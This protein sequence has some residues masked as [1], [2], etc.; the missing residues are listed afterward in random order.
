MKRVGRW[1][2]VRYKNNNYTLQP[3][4]IEDYFNELY[5]PYKCLFVTRCRVVIK[6]ILEMENVGR[7]EDVFI[8]PHSPYC[9]IEA[10]GKVSVPVTIPE[11]Q[12][13]KDIVYHQYGYRTVVGNPKRA[14]IIIEDA[15]DSLIMTSDEKELFPNDGRFCVFSLSKIIGADWGGIVICNDQDD[16]LHL[17]GILQNSDKITGEIFSLAYE[18]DQLFATNKPRLPYSFFEVN[19]YRFPY[20]APVIDNIDKRMESAKDKIIEN[21]ERAQEVLKKEVYY[22]R[23]RL[24]SNLIFDVNERIYEHIKL[25]ED[26]VIVENERL[27]HDYDSGHGKKVNL[28]PVH[29]E[30]GNI[31][32]GE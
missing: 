26:I 18:N 9:L 30:A 29:M 19:E 6:L 3:Q 27:Y 10:I 23:S 25:K 8:Q 16:Y 24:P 4:Y 5:F 20:Y 12:C 7:L 28:F 2:E 32:I 1:P 31:L 21:I 11:K 22:S 14:N 13:T 15:A 17:K